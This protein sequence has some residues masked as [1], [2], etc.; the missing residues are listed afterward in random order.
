M[1]AGGGEGGTGRRGYSQCSGDISL[2]PWD[3]PET[4]TIC[5]PV[6]GDLTAEISTYGA[7][8][9]TGKDGAAGG[10]SSY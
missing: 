6:R 2:A 4:Q 8:P 7:P 10:G 5:V 3:L 1:G 9:P